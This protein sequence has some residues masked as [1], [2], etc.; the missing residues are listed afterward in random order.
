MSTVL[1]AATIYLLGDTNIIS[2]TY[3]YFYPRPT[4]EPREMSPLDMLHNC[5]GQIAAVKYWNHDSALKA[6][7]VAQNVIDVHAQMSVEALGMEKDL[8]KSVEGRRF[9]VHLAGRLR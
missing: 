3:Q 8:D 5:L 4:Y 2:H 6:C 7:S 1:K 9:L